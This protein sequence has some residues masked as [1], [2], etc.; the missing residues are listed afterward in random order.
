METSH[1]PRVPPE[2]DDATSRWFARENSSPC[3]VPERWVLSL[4]PTLWLEV[5]VF[6]GIV[7]K[8]IRARIGALGRGTRSTQHRRLGARSRRCESVYGGHAAGR[9]LG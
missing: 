4:L 1:G 7:D 9:R 5:S 3:G 6:P 2:S 8:V